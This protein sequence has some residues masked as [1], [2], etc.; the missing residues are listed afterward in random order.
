MEQST[1][2]IRYRWVVF[3]LAAFYFTYGFIGTDHNFVGWQYR[4]L[5]NWAMTLSTISAFLM[6]QRSLGR[7]DQRHEVLASA[8]MVINFMVVLLY[9]KIYLSDPTQFY[10]DGVRTSPAWQEYYLHLLGPVLQWIDAL[11]ILG[12]F[13]HIK[14]TIG[15]AVS[16]TLI[17]VVWIEGIVS[18]FNA[19]PIGSVT[20]G[21]PYRFLNNLELADR[22]MFYIQ[23]IAVAVIMALVFSALSRVLRKLNLAPK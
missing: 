4:Y 1:G 15:L 19:S 6:L 5:T 20:T 21:L 14:K 10:V 2:V 7:R 13:R 12:T 18:P 17:Y 11:F 9:W 3:L 16:I 8:T 22:G 23:N